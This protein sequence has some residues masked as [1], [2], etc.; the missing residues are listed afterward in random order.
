MSTKDDALVEIAREIRFFHR[1]SCYPEADPI[2]LEVIA[3]KVFAVARR[4]ILE[5]AA[6]VAEGAIV[7]QHFVYGTTITS[8]TAYQIAAELR[9]LANQEQPQ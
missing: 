7:N 2:V 3:R 8:K 6:V 9:S 4:A 1:D 5:E